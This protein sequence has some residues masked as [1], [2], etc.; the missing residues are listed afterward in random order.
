M[1]QTY[2]LRAKACLSQTVLLFGGILLGALLTLSAGRLGYLDFG[3]TD[4]RLEELAPIVKDI[5]PV[6]VTIFP[7]KERISPTADLANRLPL[8][9]VSSRGTGFIVSADGYIVTNRHVVQGLNNIMIRLS[10]RQELEALLVGSDESIDLALLKIEVGKTLPFAR[11]GNS[12]NME[13]GDWVIALGNPF[14]LEHTVTVGI[15]SAKGRVI[16]TGQYDGFFQTDA[17]INPGNSGG[18]LMNLKGEVI[19]INTAIAG[20]S[21]AIGFA[22]PSDLARAKIVPLMQSH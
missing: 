22:I 14:G 20:G 3:A 2:L 7:G 19:G 17:A 18:P 6:L 15:I 9:I 5:K 11:F 21:G 16:G 13:A 4:A 12:S 8:P 10:N 1:K